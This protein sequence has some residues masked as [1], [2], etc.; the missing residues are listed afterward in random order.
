MIFYKGSNYGY[1][2]RNKTD[3]PVEYIKVQILNF[4]K[5]PINGPFK[6]TLSIV[7]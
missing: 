6:V 2:M 7:D 1:N 3:D 5:K 4:I